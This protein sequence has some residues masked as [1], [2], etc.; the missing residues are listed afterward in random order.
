MSALP[1]S[2]KERVSRNGAVHVD[3]RDV[4]APE[5][6]ICKLNVSLT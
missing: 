5:A 2:V 3:A 6:E 1:R 4:H